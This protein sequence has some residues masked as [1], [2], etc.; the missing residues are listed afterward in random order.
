MRGYQS[1]RHCDDCGYQLRE[2]QYGWF[3]ELPYKVCMNINHDKVE[4]RP[5][6]IINLCRSQAAQMTQGQIEAIPWSGSTT[7]PAA[8]VP[9]G[10]QQNGLVAENPQY[11]NRAR[12]LREQL[13]LR[14][15]NK[16]DVERKRGPNH[17]TVQ[18]I[19][20]GSDV[21]VDVLEK[22]ATALSAKGGKIEPPDIPDN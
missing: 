22:L 7:E 20:D 5:G 17:K 9:A 6:S 10:G 13:K 14:S 15:W 18:R 12:W 21:R 8:S 16:H 1:V 4:Y 2:T 19:L 11:K 3:E